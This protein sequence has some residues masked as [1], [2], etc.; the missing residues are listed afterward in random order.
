MENAH[1]GISA[2]LQAGAAMPACRGAAIGTSASSSTAKATTTR[3]VAAECLRPG[4]AAPL[5]STPPWSDAKGKRQEIAD[6]NRTDVDE[7][8]FPR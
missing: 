7:Q 3:R 2:A 1:P 6:G 4:P 5:G 8:A